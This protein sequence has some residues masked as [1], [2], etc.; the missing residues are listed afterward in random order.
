MFLASDIMKAPVVE[1]SDTKSKQ[2]I[3]KTI[4][5]RKI[6]WKKFITGANLHTLGAKKKGE[7][8]QKC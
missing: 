5:Y 1:G 2:I 6:V 3:I 7:I 8:G 4:S